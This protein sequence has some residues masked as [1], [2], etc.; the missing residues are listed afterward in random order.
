MVKVWDM[1]KERLVCCKETGYLTPVKS[2]KSRGEYMHYCGLYD[3]HVISMDTRCK[4]VSNVYQCPMNGQNRLVSL[5][6]TDLHT[7]QLGDFSGNLYS[8]DLRMTDAPQ[9]CPSVTIMNYMTD[10][11]RHPNLPMMAATSL[12][13]ELQ[14]LNWSGEQ[15][16]SVR[17]LEGFRAASLGLLQG[18]AMHPLDTVVA[19]YNRKGIVYIYN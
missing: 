9:A 11:K 12:N 7:I 3:G 14:I 17:T 6:F 13:S 16:Q 15:R 10:L 4:E 8:V 2:I 19:T 1:E 18:V 5:D